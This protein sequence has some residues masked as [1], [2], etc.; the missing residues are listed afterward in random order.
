MAGGEIINM[1][2]GFGWRISRHE[3]VVV[4]L[5]ALALVLLINQFTG[6]ITNILSIAI[7]VA[8]ISQAN[9]YIVDAPETAI[10]NEQAVFA[11]A[12]DNVGSRPL[13]GAIYVEI[14]DAGNAVVDSFNSS[15]YSIQPGSYITDTISWY[16]TQ[17]LGN[18]SIF[19]WDNYT[20][21]TDMDS[22]NFSIACLAGTYRC[23]GDERRLCS[24]T[25][26]DLVEVC[27]YGC[28]NGVCIP[29]PPGGRGPVGP[30]VPSYNMST[31][32]EEVFR[33]VQGM[34]Y[35]YI[36]RVTNNGGAALRNLSLRAWSVDIA[37]RVPDIRVGA[38]SP[39]ESV[40]FI[41]DIGVPVIPLGDYNI[42]WEVRSLEIT[43]RGVIVARVISTIEEYGFRERCLDSIERYFAVIDSLD[44][45]IRSAE[46]RG[47]DMDA[48]KELLRSA[49]EELE[50]M[51]TL[52]D[53]GLYEECSDRVDVLRRKI[54]QTAMVYAIAIS[55]PVSIIAY[56]WI[57]HVILIFTIIVLVVII[58]LMVG[59]R[60]IYS[61]YRRNR[62]ILPKRW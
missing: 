8:P 6:L 42:S 12:L 58:V 53:K 45:D 3:R 60:R 10:E 5:A 39:G 25:S 20:N 34:N 23:F 33:V 13:E 44:M 30:A 62:L 32:Y 48:A 55:R 50:V 29:A 22:S 26:W 61:W 51:R 16:A 18:Y 54:E 38:L 52:R 49:L 15:P 7:S 28:Q 4:I 21:S 47:Y 17:P 35:T 37:V 41:L 36:F 14:R 59:W 11:L 43:R 24:G 46:I 31:E 40:S 27:A 57:E 56:P 2:S 19:A 1:R 9:I